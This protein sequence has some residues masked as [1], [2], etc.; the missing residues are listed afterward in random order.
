MRDKMPESIVQTFKDRALSLALLHYRSIGTENS[1]EEVI[2][3]AQK[4]YKYL[5]FRREE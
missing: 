4:F 2:E 1:V 3:I 5:A